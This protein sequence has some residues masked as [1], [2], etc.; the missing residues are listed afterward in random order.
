MKPAGRRER[1]VEKWWEI[2]KRIR[3]EEKMRKIEEKLRKAGF[4]TMMETRAI[5][6]DINFVIYGARPGLPFLFTLSIDY[7]FTTAEPTSIY[8]IHVLGDV[9]L[10]DRLVTEDQDTYWLPAHRYYERLEG[11][12]CPEK[13]EGVF[14]TLS[15]LADEMI[16]WE[17]FSWE[18]TNYDLS[19]GALYV[20]IYG[21]GYI[22]LVLLTPEVCYDRRFSQSLLEFLT[23]I[24]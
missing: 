3:A 5:L 15:A 18:A 4:R 19:P 14:T 20:R 8:L 9:A 13:I 12:F 10:L 23:L 2:L 7:E 24:I 17:F 11:P 22:M 16:N 6:N 1:K 21:R